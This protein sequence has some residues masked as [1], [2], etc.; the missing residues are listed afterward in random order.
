MLRQ[1]LL[2]SE[3]ARLDKHGAGASCGASAR[4][5]ILLSRRSDLLVQMSAQLIRRLAE[6]LLF[7]LVVGILSTIASGIGTSSDGRTHLC[8]LYCVDG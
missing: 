2:L 1:L 5:T 3:I 8:I 4:S 7:K 6:G